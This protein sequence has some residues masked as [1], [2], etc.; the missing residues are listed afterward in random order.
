MLFLLLRV[1][2]LRVWLALCVVLGFCMS[3]KEIQQ[4]VVALL[5]HWFAELLVGC[6]FHRESYGFHRVMDFH[7]ES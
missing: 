4:T 7:S 3:S 5:I 6:C 1:H 2:Y